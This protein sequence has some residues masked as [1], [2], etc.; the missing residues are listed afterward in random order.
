MVKAFAPVVT[1]VVLVSF[2][3]DR[4]DVNV[5]LAITVIVAGCFTASYGQTEAKSAQLGLACMLICE[6]AE[7]FRSAG[8]QYL[9]ATKS[10]SLF[11]G[12]YYFSPATLLFLCVLVYLFEWEQLKDPEHLAAISENPFAFLAASCLG[13]FVNL[14]SL[15]V[16]QNAV[17]AFPNPESGGDSLRPRV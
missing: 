6:V 5:V 11:D 1:F 4:F 2:K 8:M 17:R 16:I 12:M 3:L 13:F 15:A 14:A 9:L 7:A 10:F